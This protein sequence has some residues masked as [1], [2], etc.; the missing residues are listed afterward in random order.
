MIENRK[1][2]SEN[3]IYALQKKLEKELSPERY[4]HTLG[5][6]YTAAALAMCHDPSVMEQAMIAGLLH[7]C[8]KGIPYNEQYRLCM[9][10][11]IPLSEVEEKNHAL[12]HAKLGEWM[13]KNK[14]DLKDENILHAIKVHT[15]GCPEMSM[16]DKIIY[17]SDYIEP[18]RNKAH[19]LAQ[20]RTLSF[21]NIDLA[22]E[23]IAYDVLNY[24]KKQ[25]GPTDEL[26]ISTWEW[27]H[28][29]NNEIY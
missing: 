24:L 18:G 6:M 28:H 13:A 1:N 11:Q 27:Y 26:T 21:Q 23:K 29:K 15:T 25:N 16:L 7:D 20:I 8:A 14:Y 17:I 2:N 4:H 19:H 5:V 3:R 9:K 10:Y 22:V 12:L